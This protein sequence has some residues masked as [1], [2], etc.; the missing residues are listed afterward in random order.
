MCRR[1]PL[2]RAERAHAVRMARH[3]SQ[4]EIE[5]ALA[6]VE[7]FHCNLAQVMPIY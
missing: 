3:Y 7:P 4:L 2:G 6:G 1:K 5:L